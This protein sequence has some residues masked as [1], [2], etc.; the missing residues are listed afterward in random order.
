[1]T[2]EKNVEAR[3]KRLK[4]YSN[5][6]RKLNCSVEYS[7]LSFFILLKQ[8]LVTY[9]FYSHFSISDVKK[10]LLS[11]LSNFSIKFSFHIQ[12]C[13]TITSIFCKCVLAGCIVH[14]I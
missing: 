6:R 13:E 11:F 3:D 2:G 5:S 7:S 9:L 10:V 8:L 4:S 14:M 1:M 12:N